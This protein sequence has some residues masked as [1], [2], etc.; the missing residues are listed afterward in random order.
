MADYRKYFVLIL[1][2]IFIALMPA[3]VLAEDEEEIIRVTAIELDKSEVTLVLGEET[4][5]EA[6][7]YPWNADNRWVTWSSSDPLV[8]EVESDWHT[9]RV[10]SRSQGEAVITAVTADRGLTAE[11]A[12]TVIVLPRTVG[13]EPQE[14]TL[15][16][17]DTTEIN[18]WIIP[19]EAT[20]QGIIWES[21]RPGVAS[22]NQ[23]GKVE[24]LREGET[25]IIARSLENNELTAYCRLTVGTEPVTVAETEDPVNGEA[26]A[27]TEVVPPL[28]PEPDTNYLPYI[29]GGIAIL[30][31]LAAL[32]VLLLR[33]RRKQEVL[34]QVVPQY[35]PGTRPVLVGRSGTFAGQRFYLDAGQLVIGRDHS[36]AQVVYPSDSKE[37]SRRHCTV[38][39]DYQQQQFMLEDT[40]S[41][42]TFLADGTKLSQGQQHYLYPGEYFSLSETADESFTV[43]LE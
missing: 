43:E 28:E 27:E 19:R 40:S 39:Y 26:E 29:L 34:Q 16:P 9:A 35:A 41:N 24:A 4:E 18:A 12:V 20:E 17:G 8:A 3:F 31:I 1:V 30:L 42:G 15:A 32:I 5:L 13:I 22:V 7:V 21:S 14:L 37:I 33:S 6:T 25:R 38:Y 11:M 2:I 23:D 36:V 10:I